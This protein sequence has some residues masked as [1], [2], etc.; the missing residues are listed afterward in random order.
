MELFG[1]ESGVGKS[2]VRRR[3]SRGANLD[4]VTGFEFIAE[5]HQTEVVT[6]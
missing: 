3:L 5:Q 6:H 1:G 4:L 2:G